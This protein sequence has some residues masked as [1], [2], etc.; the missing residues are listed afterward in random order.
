MASIRQLEVSLFDTVAAQCESPPAAWVLPQQG[1]VLNVPLVHSVPHLLSASRVKSI[2]KL[3]LRPDATWYVAALRLRC[4]IRD[5][6]EQATR[7]LVIIIASIAPE[8]AGRLLAM[9]LC[10]PM[11]Q[12]ASTS[13]VLDTLMSAVADESPSGDMR[14]RPGRVSFDDADLAARCAAALAQLG[15]QTLA[16]NGPS[17][18]QPPG[19]ALLRDELS[20]RL[21][22]VGENL[23]H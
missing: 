11:D 12:P 21:A 3:E 18:P 10:D 7:P 16:S 2:K 19:L 22:H 8:G 1:T 15:A 23:S 13:Y 6:S 20:K 17:N 9:R 4:W 14:Y 5:A